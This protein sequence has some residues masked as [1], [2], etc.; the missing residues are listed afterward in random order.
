MPS[1][2]ESMKDCL[3]ACT[4]ILCPKETK[5]FDCVSSPEDNNRRLEE[6]TSDLHEQVKDEFTDCSQSSQDSLGIKGRNLPLP[7]LERKGKIS[8]TT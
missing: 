1:M 3:L 6:I 7:C 2:R 5:T 4:D 8:R